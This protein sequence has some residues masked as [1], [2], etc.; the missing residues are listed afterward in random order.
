MVRG[1]HDEQL[2]TIHHY[3]WVV[4]VQFFLFT[5]CAPVAVTCRGH[6]MFCGVV[7][8]MSRLY[9]ASIAL[10]LLAALCAAWQ[11]SSLRNE[12]N[13]ALKS[14]GAYKAV[15]ATQNATITALREEGEVKDALI[16]NWKNERDTDAEYRE[17]QR[18][19]TEHTLTTDTGFSGW[20]A[21]PLPDAV[22]SGRLFGKGGA[23][24][25]NPGGVP[26]TP[27]GPPGGNG[28]PAPTR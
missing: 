15:A 9:A 13:E 7:G 1:G 4:A 27:G 3:L 17:E 25:T 14:A 6:C 19:A 11:I 28:A 18:D 20:A 26:A 24:G 2:E 23:A 10:V 21:A 16:T 22:L 5:S 8:T 12:R